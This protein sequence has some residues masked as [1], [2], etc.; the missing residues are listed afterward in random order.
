MPGRRATVK[1]GRRAILSVFGSGSSVEQRLRVWRSSRTL[2]REGHDGYET[3]RGKR[4][5][6]VEP[7]HVGRAP[8]GVY[9]FG[10]CDLPALFSIAPFVKPHLSRPLVVH[11]AP[12][13]IDR[14]RVDVALQPLGTIDEAAARD[15]IK[16]LQLPLSYFGRDLF[17]RTFVTG[18]RKYPKLDKAVVV[19]TGGANAVRT[20]YRHK[21]S[22]LLIDPGARWLDDRNRMPPED[23]SWFKAN[24]EKAGRLTVDE[25]ADGLARL[26][27]EIRQRT[28]ATVL[29]FNTLTVEPGA[30][31]HNYQLRRNPETR[32]RLEFHLAMEEL[33]PRA[34]F[35]VV[36][37]DDA[38]KRLGIREYLDFAHFPTY[39]NEPIARA[40]ARLLHELE[41]L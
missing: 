33:A 5:L 20:A 32:R 37:V 18:Y 9:L 13:G 34:G 11:R 41:L 17:E 23:M 3:V 14:A 28:G 8:L 25:F 15:A 29:V 39:A 21:A 31:D 30:L 1:L 12:V 40:T 10:G 27:G 35:H 6:V 7:E 36:D 4:L 22:G 24:Y 2:E 19:L 16:R 26:V 38:L